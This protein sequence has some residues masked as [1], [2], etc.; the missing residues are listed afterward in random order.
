MPIHVHGDDESGSKTL[1]PPVVNELVVVIK[2]FVFWKLVD[3]RVEVAVSLLLFVQINFSLVHVRDYREL[4]GFEFRK[5]YREISHSVELNAN[6]WILR[7]NF[8]VS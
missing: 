2:N 6:N 1:S 3:G 7:Q 5:I 8:L 4:F